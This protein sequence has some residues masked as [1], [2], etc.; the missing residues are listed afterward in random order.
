VYEG[1]YVATEFPIDLDLVERVEVIR[2]PGS[3]LYGTDAFL[4]VINVITKRGSDF[5]GAEISGS[6]ASRQTFQARATYGDQPEHGP[7]VLFSGTFY[8]SLGN[9]QLYY[10]E[11]NSRETNN[12]YAVDPDGEAARTFFASA[13]YG[14]FAFEGVYGSRSKTVPTAPYGTV[15]NGPRT[16][17]TDAHG[18]VDAQY[19]HTL[20]SGWELWGHLAFDQYNYQGT[21]VIDILGTGVAPFTLNEDFAIGQWFTLAFD[22]S[23]VIHEQ[24][25][26]TLGT[27]ERWNTKQNQENYNLDPYELHLNDRRSSVDASFYAQDEYSVRTNLILMG[28]LRFD[29]DSRFGSSFNP[30]VGMI[31]NPWKKTTLKILYGQA[32]RAPNVFE[33]F[34]ADGVS[35]KANPYLNPEKIKT[36]EVVFEQFFTKH[37]HFTAAGFYNRISDLIS[38]ETDPTDGRL[39]FVN[40]QKVSGKGLDLELAGKWPSGWQGRLAYTLEDTRDQLTGT[41]LSNSAKHLAKIDL[42]APLIRRRLFASFDSQY[43]SARQ[44]IDGGRAGAYFVA[45]ATIFAPLAV[46]G[47]TVSASAYN[48]FDRRYAD[49][50]GPEHQQAALPQDG[51]TVALKLTYRFGE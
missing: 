35:S 37:T 13:Q 10:P 47:L 31:Y 49:P 39:Q 41:R 24:H 16:R 12:G 48:L 51:R 22:V 30:R 40:W 4:A 5:Q 6:A 38:E 26:V 11:F 43:L 19:D 20:A 1:V 25:H 27:E 50:G 44:T 36:A 21:Y 3:A 34:Y 17:T 2:G 29:H 9:H 8:H 28:G 7:Q 33:M 15:F 42:T 45:N 23:R 18:Y 32:F 46:K 14:D